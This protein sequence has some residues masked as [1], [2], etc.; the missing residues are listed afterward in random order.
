MVHS[1][2]LYITNNTSC[3]LTSCSTES[4]RINMKNNALGGKRLIVDSYDSG[5]LNRNVTG[6]ES[7]IIFFNLPSSHISLPRKQMHNADH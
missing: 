6:N 4:Q 1:M 2:P 3:V 5:I 7:V